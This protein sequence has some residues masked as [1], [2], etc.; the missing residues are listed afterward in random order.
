MYSMMLFFGLLSVGYYAL[1]LRKNTAGAWIG[2][3]LFTFLGMFTHYFFSFLVLGEVGYFLW[4]EIVRAEAALWRQGLAG[5][6]RSRPFAIFGDLPKLGPWLLSTAFLAATFGLWLARSVFLPQSSEGGLVS[7]ATGSGLGYGQAAPSL[8]FRFND[9][10]LV[11]V[12]MLAGFH[13]GW[14]MYAFVAMW[15]LLISGMLLLLDV[16]KPIGRTS[17]MLLCASSGVLVIV[18]LGQWQGQVLASRYFIAVAAPVALLIAGVIGF[19][20]RRSRIALL[21]V[22]AVLCVAAWTSQSFDHN[23]LVRFDNREAIGYVAQ[24]YQPGEVV[25]YEPFYLDPLFSYYMPPRVPVYP[26]PQYGKFGLLRNGKVQLGQDLNR[27]VGPARRVWLILSFQNI[28]ALRGDAYNTTMW[29][30]R[31]GYHIKQNKAF[32]Q[33][34]VIEFESNKTRPGF[35]VPGGP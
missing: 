9:V 31:H 23:N 22:G 35:V 34:Q 6:A 1:A 3:A 4:F 10:G 11:I 28:E 29:F 33:V 21:T 16:M 17:A 12:E 7:S 32:N 26:F 14:A 2:Y 19:M 27:V 18:A 15:P 24:N 5:W 25:I 20:P 30:L 13:P 8:A